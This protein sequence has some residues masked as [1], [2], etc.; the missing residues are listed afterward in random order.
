MPARFPVIPHAVLRSAW[1]EGN[2]W[3][4]PARPLEA[5]RT[6]RTEP[7]TTGPGDEYEHD[8]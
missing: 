6:I 8:D 7:P 3:A 4:N 1:R 5:V 2:G